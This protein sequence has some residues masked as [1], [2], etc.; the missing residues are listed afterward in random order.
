MKYLI[1]V[2]FSTL[3]FWGCFQT[4]K[5]ASTDV[6]ENVGIY[7]KINFTDF[8]LEQNDIDDFFKTFPKYEIFLTDV[9]QYY[10][11][12]QYQYA[13][14][15]NDGMTIAVSNFQNQ[16][17][18]YSAD[19]DDKTILNPEIDKLISILKSEQS[20]K[21]LI[22]KSTKKLELLLTTT[23]F[24]YSKK[25]YHGTIENPYNLNWYIP[26]KKKSYQTLLDSLVKPENSTKNWE[27]T[28]QLYSLLKIKLREYR[29]LQKKGGLPYIQTSKKELSLSDSDSCI[30]KIKQYLKITGDLSH[31][32]NTFY[33]TDSLAKSI[34][35]FQHRFGLIESGKIDQETIT[36]LNKPIGFRIKQIMINME[37]LRWFPDDLNENYILINIPEFKLHVF[38]NGNKIWDSK[39]VV[40]KEINKTSIFKGTISQIIINPYWNVPNSIINKEMLPILKKNRSYLSKNNFEVLSG[41][42]IINPYAINWHNYTKN[43][44]Y[45]I[46]QKPGDNNALGKIKFLFPNNFHIYLHDT[47]S[48]YLFNENKRAF[49]H[50]CIRVEDPRKLALY[51][52]RN[53]SKW[54]EEQFDKSLNTK[55]TE[56]I[57]LKQKIEVFIVYFTTWVDH[58]N[59]INFRN[60][61][62]GLDNQL[63]KEV[64]LN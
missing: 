3:L 30:A 13:W 54:N 36:E 1:V 38:E 23:F 4:K 24:I 37:R 34:T 45:A 48:K 63:E 26:K 25:V 29:N 40:G 31:N 12:R 50:G 59:Q 62:Y 7:T 35:R 39:V 46:R 2:V 58:N 16:I 42:K 41:N 27:P 22:E 11:N 53:D 61:L 64:F 60:D 5:E 8:I 19:F 52:L 57:N 9:T 51:L 47:P 6:F 44:P 18:N 43:I 32:D 21:N 49:S 15:N 55:K 10:I 56:Y 20:D 14:F 33:F 28:N 17:Q